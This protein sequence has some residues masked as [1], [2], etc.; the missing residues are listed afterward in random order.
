MKADIR[1]LA[2]FVAALACPLGAQ[3]PAP[4]STAR[5]VQSLTL[6][7]AIAMGQQR[8][9]AA[10]IARNV[11]D[12]ARD[13]N[14]GFNARLL[15]QVVLQGQAANL[16]HSINPITL[17]D[18]SIQY[19]G[20][21]Q[22]QS[23]LGLSVQQSIPVTGS[24]LSVSTQMS[25]L[26]LFGDQTSRLYSTTPVLLTL[27]QDLFKPRTLVWNEK[28]QSLNASVAE[29]GYY[30]AR[31]DVAGAIAGAFFD[32]YSG[33]MTY[34]NAAANA[35]VNDT[36]YTLNKG[37]YEVGKISENDLLN[38]ELQLLRARASVDDAKLQRDRAEAALRRLI[39]FPTDRQFTIVTPDSIPTIDADPDVAVKEALKNASAIQQNDL[40][41]T[42]TQREI[43]EAKLNN[44][45]N[46][47]ISASVG[48][49][50]TSRARE[51][52]QQSARQ[53]VA[54]RR[55]EHADDP[56]GG[57]PLGHRGRAGR[58]PASEREQ[59]VAHRRARRGLP[60]LGAGTGSGPAK[61]VDRRQGR[62]GG[63]KAVRR[64][65]EP[66]R[67]RQDLDQ[68]SLHRAEREGPGGAVLR[69]GPAWVLDG[70]LPSPAR[71]AVRFCDEARAGG[72]A[73]AV[74]SLDTPQP[75]PYHT[76]HD[77]PRGLLLLLLLRDPNGPWVESYA[78]A[79]EQRRAPS[80]TTRELHGSF[81]FLFITAPH[82]PRSTP[83]A[84][85]IIVTRPKVTD[86]EIDHIRE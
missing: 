67:D 76:L 25:R 30:E 14:D 75:R 54:R 47:T 55:R 59:Q 69:A 78:L 84:A 23:T 38:S 39:I 3:T 56:V 48:F 8:G 27:Q 41:K 74:A 65:E 15:S 42:Q 12:A 64:R 5:Q 77:A 19:I 29:R 58:R 53:A 50:Q 31:E 60:F 33:Q 36:L 62:H 10:E 70:L 6:Q 44:R 82:A 46:A 1:I 79:T 21:A 37:R 52:V 40:D 16:N 26:D 51:L 81:L 32:L 80:P 57:R 63:R 18:G 9:P 72:R 49:N 85:M 61:R 66:V 43:T 13:R 24:V 86:A 68:R 35:S 20:Q 2:P 28:I 7:E 34:D 71:H 45:F 17:P 73:R 83:N 22:N 4:L 11:R